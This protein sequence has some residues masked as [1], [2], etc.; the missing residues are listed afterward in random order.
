MTQSKRFRERGRFVAHVAG[1][2]PVGMGR[3][4]FGAQ[5]SRGTTLKK[6]LIPVAVGTSLG[7][8]LAP[9]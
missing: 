9:G 5:G 4:G 1:G 8:L 6:V 3:A 2:G 7:S